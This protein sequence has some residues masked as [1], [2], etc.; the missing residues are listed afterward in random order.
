VDCVLENSG[1]GYFLV[2]AYVDKE[3]AGRLPALG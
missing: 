2:I 3:L 1:S